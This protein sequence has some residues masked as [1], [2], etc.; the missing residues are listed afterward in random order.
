MHAPEPR[1]D[2]QMRFMVGSLIGISGTEDEQSPCL[3]QQNTDNMS[4]MNET[5]KTK[6]EI[7][8]CN[9]FNK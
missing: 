1:L 5:N 4:W 3:S 2:F 7:D 9:K 6:G 8:K